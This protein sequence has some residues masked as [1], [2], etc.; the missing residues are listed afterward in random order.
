MRSIFSDAEQLADPAAHRPKRAQGEIAKTEICGEDGGQWLERHSIRKP[1]GINVGQIRFVQ[2]AV[3]PRIN[4]QDRRFPAK[5]RKSLREQSRAMHTGQI[6]RGK[7][8]GDDDYTFQFGAQIKD[9][10]ARGAAKR[11]WAS[12]R[13][14][15][16]SPFGPNWKTA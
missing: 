5:F 10:F 11:F 8:R 12:V 15:S 4:R 6:A 1:G 3:M 14:S 7:I 2:A 9:T 13:P 16:H